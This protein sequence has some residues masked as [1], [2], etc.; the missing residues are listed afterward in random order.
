[1]LET[2]EERKIRIKQLLISIVP[3]GLILLIT[4]YVLFGVNRVHR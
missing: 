3:I 2:N 4:V 1:M